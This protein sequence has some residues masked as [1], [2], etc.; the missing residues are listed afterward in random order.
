MIEETREYKKAMIFFRNKRTTYLEDYLS[1]ERRQHIHMN[2]EQRAWYR[3]AVDSLQA[4][5]KA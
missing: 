3:A 1:M 5:R 2:S 4:L